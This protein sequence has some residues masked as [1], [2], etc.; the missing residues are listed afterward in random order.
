MRKTEAGR[1]ALD[2]RLVPDI[3]TMEKA[4]RVREEPERYK[5][6]DEIMKWAETLG[7]SVQRFA[8]VL[9]HELSGKP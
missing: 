7:E 6:D 9:E 3:E 8:D 5:E 4:I 1:W 2:N